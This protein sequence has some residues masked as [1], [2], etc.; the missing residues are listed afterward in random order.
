MLLPI[1]LFLSLQSPLHLQ[2]WFTH[3][4]QILM[5]LLNEAITNDLLKYGS[6]TS[7]LLQ[8]PLNKI[9]TDQTLWIINNGLVTSLFVLSPTSACSNVASSWQLTSHSIGTCLSPFSIPHPTKPPLPALCESWKHKNNTK[10]L[11]WW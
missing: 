10:S 3:I 2:H 1:S 9:S 5:K 4:S 8:S 7:Y 6:F 11:L